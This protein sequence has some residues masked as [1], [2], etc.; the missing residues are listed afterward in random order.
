MTCWASRR[1]GEQRANF[2]YWVSNSAPSDVF[3]LQAVKR[4]LVG[5]ALEDV[6]LPAELAG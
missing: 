4:A 6:D 5:D 1:E 3:A 2:P